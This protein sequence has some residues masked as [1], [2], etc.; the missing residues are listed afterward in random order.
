MKQIIEEIKCF[1]YDMNKS[2]KHDF[3]NKSYILDDVINQI[4]G[5]LR[6]EPNTKDALVIK[7]VNY[8][9]L[10]SDS[11]FR[12]AINDSITIDTKKFSFYNPEKLINVKIHGIC[13]CP[14]YLEY[15]YGCVNNNYKES[16]VK[17]IKQS[18]STSYDP[19]LKNVVI[20]SYK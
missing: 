18:I 7:N 1:E 4:H 13:I 3:F 12:I 9:Q 11:I 15:V 8:V 6:I 10:F 16:A 17:L 14:I 19:T 20:K 2:E 5:K